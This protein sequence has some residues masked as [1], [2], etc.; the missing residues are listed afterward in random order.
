MNYAVTKIGAL[1]TSNYV[2]LNPITT[3]IASSIILHEPMTVMSIAGSIL[4]L[5]GLAI[6]NRL[7]I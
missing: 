5:I 7:D 3:L 2:Y 6:V 4:I 1:K